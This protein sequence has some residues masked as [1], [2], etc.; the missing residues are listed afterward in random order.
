MTTARQLEY[1]TLNNG[2]RVVCEQVP[3]KVEYFGVAVN[4]GSRDEAQHLH[5][6]AHFVEHTLF[7]GT[8]RRRACHI[9]NRMEAIGGEL[10]AFTSKEETNVYSI[11]PQGHLPRAAELIA[12]LLQNSV[13]PA[14]E[15][16]KEREVVREEIDSYLDTP[17]EAVFDEF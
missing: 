2:L 17:S 3:S 1:Y 11:F 8:T 10:N 7:K 15:L 5:G 4:A 12:D 9:I 6:L 14:K 16:D 13:F